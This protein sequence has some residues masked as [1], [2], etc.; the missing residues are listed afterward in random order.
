MPKRTKKNVENDVEITFPNFL[1]KKG[2]IEILQFLDDEPGG[3]RKVDFRKELGLGSI[4]A[5]NAQNLMIQ[6]G[7]IEVM[8]NSNKF[9]FRLSEKGKTLVIILNFLQQIFEG[10]PDKLEIFSNMQK[11]IQEQ[12]KRSLEK[13][14]DSLITTS[15]NE[16]PPRSMKKELIAYLEKKHNA[17]LKELF[18][19]LG[20]PHPNESQKKLG[21]SFILGLKN[22]QILDFDEKTNLFSLN[23]KYK[24]N[25]LA[26]GELDK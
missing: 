16:M 8:P 15:E 19:I 6:I 1:Q 26:L 25:L 11:L 12:E 3:K 22:N 23:P 4:T 10:D 9:L 17:T 2:V 24:L 21:L 5:I 7:L 13:L 20:S 18:E 14:F